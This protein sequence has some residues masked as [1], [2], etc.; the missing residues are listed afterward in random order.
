MCS[1]YEYDSIAIITGCYPFVDGMKHL[2]GRTATVI[3][4]TGSVLS[5][6]F[7]DKSGDIS[8]NFTAEMIDVI[9]KRDRNDVQVGDRVIFRNWDDMA[10]EFGVRDDFITSPIVV[11]PAMMEFCGKKATVTDI[12]R[13]YS[14]TY[15]SLEFDDQSISQSFYSITT[16]MIALLS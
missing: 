1:E 7:D 6:D 8:W 16:D 14:N 2:C 5:L 9:A 3:R 11:S 15:I 13:G 4:V 10:A 12:D